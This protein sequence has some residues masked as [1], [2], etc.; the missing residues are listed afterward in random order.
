METNVKI[1]LNKCVR[2]VFKKLSTQ[3]EL[4]PDTIQFIN[5]DFSLR[6]T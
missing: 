6:T 4:D 2:D 5:D 1:V 3:K